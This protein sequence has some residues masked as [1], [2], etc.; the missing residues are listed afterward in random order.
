MYFLDSNVL[1]YLVLG[2]DPRKREV[3]LSLVGRLVPYRKGCISMQVLREVANVMFKKSRNTLEFI[4]E[5]I[6]GFYDL[7]CMEDTVVLLERGME[8]KA[9]YGLQFYD[10]LVVATAKA[11]GC[12]TIYSEDMADGAQYDG[13]L[14]VNPFKEGFAMPECDFPAV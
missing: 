3:A 7:P 10:A 11:A 8:I 6:S 4:R 1:V 2:Q 14:V 9:R 12:D 5:T 13:V